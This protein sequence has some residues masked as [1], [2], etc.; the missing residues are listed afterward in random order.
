MN[1][2]FDIYDKLSIAINSGNGRS[3]NNI[4]FEI[5]YS[6]LSKNQVDDRL[7]SIILNVLTQAENYPEI[8]IEKI[9][10]F[11]GSDFGK[12]TKVQSIRLLNS[13]MKISQN[14]FVVRLKIIIGDLIGHRYPVSAA[15]DFCEVLIKNVNLEKNHQHEMTP[16][17]SAVFLWL[18]EKE[19]EFSKS[20]FTSYKKIRKFIGL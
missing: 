19:A 1:N 12:F 14:E 5:E 7:I 10:L 11:I 15:L 18:K 4:L 6:N 2:S 9:I 13:L 8:S 16:I 17:L 3:L 20:Q